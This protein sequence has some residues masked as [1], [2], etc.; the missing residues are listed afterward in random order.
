MNFTLQPVNIA[1]RHDGEGQ[2]V[3][4]D[5][6]L[7]A[8]LVRLSD[9]HDDTAG[10]WFL[11]FGF[12]DLDHPPQAIFPNLEAALDWIRARLDAVSTVSPAPS[13]ARRRAARSRRPL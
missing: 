12:E 4:A 5:G 3:F 10:S 7:L 2:L 8:I 6:R 9:I 11:E 1:N 13:P